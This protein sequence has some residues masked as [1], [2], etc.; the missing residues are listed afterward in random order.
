VFF[1][2][3]AT[4]YPLSVPVSMASLTLIESST[5]NFFSR[6]MEFQRQTISYPNTLQDIRQ[7]YDLE[8]MENKVVDGDRPFPENSESLRHGVTIEFR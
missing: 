1:A 8:Q 3:R 6:L 2:L 5:T 4:Q 7:L